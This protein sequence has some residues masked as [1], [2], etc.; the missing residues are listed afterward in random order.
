MFVAAGVKSAVAAS[1]AVCAM[2]VVGTLSAGAY[3]RSIL[4]SN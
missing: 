1:V 2:N 3:A 4:S